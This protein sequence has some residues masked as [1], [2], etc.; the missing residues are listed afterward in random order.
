MYCYL[1]HV[2]LKA[3]GKVDEQVYIGQ[4]I[5]SGHACKQRAVVS[6][7]SS[8]C[9]M[10]YAV[11]GVNLVPVRSMLTHLKHSGRILENLRRPRHISKIDNSS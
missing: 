3:R 2:T 8:I 4:H 11:S 1:L 7:M 6:T 5:A 10:L 9:D